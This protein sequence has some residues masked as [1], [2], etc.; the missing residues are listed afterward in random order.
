MDFT[1]LSLCVLVLGAS[2]VVHADWLDDFN[3][4]CI[5]KGG[6]PVHNP[7]GGGYCKPGGGPGTGTGAANAYGAMA[8]SFIDLI[9]QIDASNEMAAKQKRA[10]LMQALENERRDALRRQETARAADLAAIQRRLMGSGLGLKGG[11]NEDGMGLKLRSGARSEPK[12]AEYGLPGRHV[13]RND[14]FV[15][16]ATPTPTETI[17]GSLL[18]LKLGEEA[19]ESLRNE[20]LGAATPKA[21]AGK[22]ATS[23]SSPRIEEVADLF[24]RL[25]PEE[26]RRIIDA[27]NASVARADANA[28]RGDANT[29]HGDAV[30]VAP[31][32]GQAA[33]APMPLKL[34]AARDSA[35]K[36]RVDAGAS[37]TSLESLKA[38]DERDLRTGGIAPRVEARKPQ[39]PSAPPPRAAKTTPVAPNEIQA[40]TE[41]DLGLLF[42][43]RI[44]PP[45]S[46]ARNDDRDLLDRF[47]RESTPAQ[48]KR[49]EDA[50]VAVLGLALMP[51][52]PLT[53]GFKA[54]ESQRRAL[55]AHFAPDLLQRYGDDPRF[56]ADVDTMIDLR[57]SQARSWRRDADLAAQQ[58]LAPNDARDIQRANADRARLL[59]QESLKRD[60]DGLAR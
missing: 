30:P 5:A 26:Q 6:T 17:A 59:L 56:A 35:D 25:P 29:S 20:P 13:F 9:N 41:A 8:N 43:D 23:A 50:R 57:V 3:R 38:R 34:S 31:A 49:A 28:S 1:R 12:P 18:T 15:D 51:D 39:P 33:S 22:D 47:Q 16:H 54:G 53:G 37:D 14:I 4:N 60:L 48:R 11:G 52:D 45:R 42:M 32:P 40:P 55:L 21:D 2:N 24:N 27:S 10:A 44:P 36:T 19:T 58:V 7:G 46:D